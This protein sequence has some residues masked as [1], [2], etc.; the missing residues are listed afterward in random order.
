MRLH[1]GVKVEARVDRNA[2]GRLRGALH[3]PA[4]RHRSA[5][6]RQHSLAPRFQ[7]PQPVRAVGRRRRRAQRDDADSLRN[8]GRT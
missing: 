4:G 5:G 7:Q 6:R 1:P 2:A 8:A 3:F